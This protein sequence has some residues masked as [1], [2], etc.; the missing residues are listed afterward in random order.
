M[1]SG[2]Q[3]ND[4][5]AGFP[6]QGYAGHYCS[7]PRRDNPKIAGCSMI[8]SGLRL[9]DISDVEHPR[10]VAYFNRPERPGSRPAF[11]DVAGAY[12]MSAP[13][14]D[15]K[16][17]QR[18]VHRRQ[19]GVLQREADQRGRL[20]GGT[21]RRAATARL[22]RQRRCWRADGAEPM[23]R[24]DALGTATWRGSRARA[25]GQTQVCGDALVSVA[26]CR[27]ERRDQARSQAANTAG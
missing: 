23:V 8:V 25:D 27:R 3:Y 20:S 10:E 16:R 12:A 15:P 9:F 1:H 18:L 7:V 19:L 22:R 13:A 14:W 21:G 4:P 17:G 11:P 2:E 24:A 5:G 6:A 26:A